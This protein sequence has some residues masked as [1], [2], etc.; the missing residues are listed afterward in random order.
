MAFDDIRVHTSP[1]GGHDRAIQIGVGAGET[2][3][4]GEPVA[5]NAAGR[6]TESASDAVDADCIGVAAAG[7]DTTAPGTMDW[8]TGILI[9]TGG[10]VPVHLASPHTYFI[11]ENFATDGAGTLAVPVITTIGDAASLVLAAGTWFVDTGGASN[12]CRIMDVLDV[13]GRSIQESGGTGVSVVFVIVA[14][15]NLT[16]G[17]A[18]DPVA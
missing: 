17:T 9:V 4:R 6:L 16:A 3:L 12:I 10:L 1:H 8:R 15:Q 11:T 13:D 2:F 14:H 7:G 18:D 5:I